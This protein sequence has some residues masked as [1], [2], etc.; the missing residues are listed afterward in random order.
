[1]KLEKMHS[2][3]V[4]PHYFIYGLIISFTLYGRKIDFLRK[5]KGNK[6][7]IYDLRETAT[8]EGFSP[9]HKVEE[10]QQKEIQEWNSQVNY[11]TK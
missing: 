3:C 1:M 4:Y 5:L 9:N 11:W 8:D 2:Y 10:K 7:D 6:I